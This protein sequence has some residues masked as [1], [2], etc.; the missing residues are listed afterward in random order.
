MEGF[1]T[2]KE[3][4]AYPCQAEFGAPLGEVNPGRMLDRNARNTMPAELVSLCNSFW[5]SG[6]FPSSTSRQN[7]DS[8]LA[9][10]YIDVSVRDGKMAAKLAH[11]KG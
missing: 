6:S 10:N 9:S 4:A 8:V 2:L 1:R 11:G 3:C 7:P 5:T